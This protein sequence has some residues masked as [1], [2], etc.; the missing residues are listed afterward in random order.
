M[1]LIR[2]NIHMDRTKCFCNT[3]ITLEEDVNIPDVKPDVNNIIYDKAIV[4]IEEVKPTEDH[5]LVRG[6][7]LFSVLYQSGDESQKLVLLEGKIPFDEQLYMEGV[8]S[9]DAVIAKAV[10]EDLQVS[11][12][13]SRKLSV[14]ALLGIRA[15]VEE[16]YD[17]EISEDIY[18]E[19]EMPLEYRRETKEIAE[20]A[21]LKN[22]ILRIR[23]E[24]G[25]P[26]NYPNIFH[27]LWDEV[28][29]ED[30]EFRPKDEC[31]QV[32]GD[33]HVFFLYEGEG[34][35]TQIR[36]H[37]TTIPINQTLECHGA[38]EGMLAD[39]GYETGHKELEVHP[40][41][42]GEE[43]MLSLEMVLDISMRLYEED[44]VDMI[45]DV[46]GVKK[47]VECEEKEA[48]LRQVYMQICGKN[49]FTDKITMKEEGQILQVLHA[50]EMA[51]V[52]SKQIV[53]NGIL[54]EGSI[55]I[56]ALVITDDDHAPYR[57]VSKVAPFS[58]TLEVSG[59]LPTD[60]FKLDYNVE[61]L[62]VSMISGDELDVKAILCFKTCIFRSITVTYMDSIRLQ[63]LDP[64]KMEEMPGMVI[65]VVGN[66]EQLWDIGKQ[67]YVSVDTLKEINELTSDEV[68]PGDKL[69][70]VK[71]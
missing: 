14:Q 36:A 58:Y 9:G 28:E 18:F 3:Q 19:E 53:E 12:I 54:I 43:R 69:L 62:Q 42:D 66:D 15:F 48:Q 6:R 7:L 8:A 13:N 45:T 33:I 16:L 37:E 70:L 29:F 47:E 56:K 39:I 71:G 46:Y 26:Q 32:Q 5:V 67:Y 61:Q 49:K 64:A 51:T 10:V 44:K 17:E 30:L 4:Q 2:K 68:H 41:F 24:I 27:I 50:C 34:E 57:C 60:T 11:T 52:D 21:I 59:I 63:D 20:I 31:I 35:E 40:D 25:I 1:E 38:K 65:Y 23:E 22:D 55:N